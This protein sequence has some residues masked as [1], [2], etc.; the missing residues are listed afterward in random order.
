MLLSCDKLK[1]SEAVCIVHCVVRP[2][3]SRQVGKVCAGR[4]RDVMPSDL[5]LS[6]SVL[7]RLSVVRRVHPTF[8]EEAANLSV[9]KQGEQ[10]PLDALRHLHAQIV[11]RPWA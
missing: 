2:F 9:V 11:E 3:G 4:H 6:N 8:I 7:P 10:D 5:E 1:Q